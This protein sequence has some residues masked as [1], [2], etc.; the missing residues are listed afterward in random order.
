MIYFIQAAAMMRLFVPIN[1]SDNLTTTV[2]Q[3]EK[4]L[5]LMLSIELSDFSYN[6]CPFKGLT[7]MHKLMLRFLFLLSIYMCWFITFGLI[8]IISKIKK[9]RG[10]FMP[11]LKIRFIKA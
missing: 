4:Y 6:L 7:T 3:I 9:R 8:K 5:G 11:T 1:T 10:N 2:Q